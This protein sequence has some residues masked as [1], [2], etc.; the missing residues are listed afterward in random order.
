MDRLPA[1]SGDFI[2]VSVVTVSSIPPHGVVGLSAISPGYGPICQP[3]SCRRSVDFIQLICQNTISNPVPERKTR[4]IIS[5]TSHDLPFIVNELS[6]RPNAPLTIRSTE[7][8]DKRA[9]GTSMTLPH[10]S[11]PLLILT[12]NH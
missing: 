7:E 5:L 9:G 10:F 6:S 12:T 1:D 3:T 8:L 2:V 4:V 11:K